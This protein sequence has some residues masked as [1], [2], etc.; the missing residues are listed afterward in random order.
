MFED[1]RFRSLLGLSAVLVF[2]L[3]CAGCAPVTGPPQ[4][5]SP[6]EAP[7]AGPQRW[8][9]GSRPYPPAELASPHSSSLAPASDSRLMRFSH[10]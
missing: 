4:A 8:A 7:V 1:M 5:R 6:R 9:L 3:S 10:R 2:V